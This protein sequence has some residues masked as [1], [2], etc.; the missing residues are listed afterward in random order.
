MYRRVGRSKGNMKNGVAVR[1]EDQNNRETYAIS[2]SNG[3]DRECMFGFRHGR[4]MRDQ[5]N[6][7]EWQGKYLTQPLPP[8]VRRTFAWFGPVVSRFRHITPFVTRNMSHPVF[9]A[10]P[11]QSLRV[12]PLELKFFFKLCRI[13][14][15]NC[16][17]CPRNVRP[18]E[19]GTDIRFP[20]F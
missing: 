9:Q 13:P 11:S 16:I 18:Q 12:A 17:L 14:Q 1:K 8:R 5:L 7:H 6:W 20:N 10:P 19:E 3:I 15:L 2:P 4:V